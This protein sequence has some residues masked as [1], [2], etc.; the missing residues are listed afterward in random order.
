MVIGCPGFNNSKGYVFFQRRNGLN[1]YNGVE[2]APLFPPANGD[3]FGESVSIGAGLN[4]GITDV[5]VGAPMKDLSGFTDTG[6]VTIIQYDS[7]LVPQFSQESA[8]PG[9]PTP[10]SN[11]QYGLSVAIDNGKAVV[12]QGVGDAYVLQRESNGGYELLTTLVGD[13]Q[14]T[15]TDFGNRVAI[16][17]DTVVVSDPLYDTNGGV[18]AGV[19]YVYDLTQI[20]PVSEIVNGQILTASDGRTGDLFGEHAVAIGDRG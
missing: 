4:S 5:M 11:T 7:A 2:V 9:T 15:P 8:S 1:S 14:V 20:D 18:D 19:V 3:R 13:I 6:T 17:R 12:G 10:V 16:S